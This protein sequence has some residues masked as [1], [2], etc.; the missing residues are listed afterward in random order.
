MNVGDDYIIY[1][2]RQDGVYILVRMDKAAEVIGREYLSIAQ[3]NRLASTV[4]N[5]RLSEAGRRNLRRKFKLLR[6]AH[7]TERQRESETNKPGSR[8]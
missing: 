3:L 1:R 4:R 8:S 5:A 2:T 7:N 6:E